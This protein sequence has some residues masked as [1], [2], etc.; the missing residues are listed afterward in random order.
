VLGGG[1]NS[2]VASFQVSPDIP[3][4]LF[5]YLDD[6]HIASYLAQLQGGAATTESLSREVTAS[7]NASV[8]ANGVGVGASASQQ[9]GAELSLT[10][11][12]QSRFT[13]LL[14]LLQA[15]GYLHKVDMAAPKA[16]V[17]REFAAVTPG[18]FVLLSNCTLALPSY[19]QAEQE[20]R[21]AR[22]KISVSEVVGGS[23]RES[24]REQLAIQVAIRDRFI[25]QG[26]KPPP[27]QLVGGSGPLFAQQILARARSQ[28]NHLVS[29]V[30]PN[31]RVPLSS[32]SPN[33]IE[34]GVPDLL[35]PIQLAA[36]SSGQNALAGHLTLVGKVVLTVP[37]SEKYYLDVA[38]LQRWSGASFWTSPNGGVGS[39]GD[40]VTVL[41]PGYVIQPIAIYK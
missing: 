10:V 40:D 29:Q 11:T 2:S 35:M 22:G 25:V 30:G 23:E 5:D 36:F 19:V 26:K 16:Q 21:A 24:R 18:S 28:M 8:G 27:L 12:N 41:A 37:K 38:L 9:S 6:V 17:R 32:C 13:S 14:G 3:P 15:N 4:V 39:L 7:K 20:W 31:P 34:P 33:G 1:H